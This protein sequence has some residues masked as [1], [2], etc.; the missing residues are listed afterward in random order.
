MKLKQKNHF[1]LSEN[2]GKIYL[3]RSYTN[4]FITLT[5]LND[6]VIICKT[7]GTSG[8]VGSK[9]RK[10]VPQAIE[11]IMKNLFSYL[12]LYKI[13]NIEIVLKIKINIFFHYLLKELTYYNIN[14]IGYTVHRAIAFN[15]TK[16]RKLRRI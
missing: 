12:R 4:I 8:L 6:K 11:N 1:V 2:T 15:G 7:S 10:N 9:R 13:S 3:N 14:I 5:D 16:G